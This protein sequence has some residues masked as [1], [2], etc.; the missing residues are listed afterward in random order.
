MGCSGAAQTLPGQELGG[1]A[2]HPFCSCPRARGCKNSASLGF[3][4]PSSPPG[5]SAGAVLLAAFLG[6]ALP[7]PSAPSTASFHDPAPFCGA[8]GWAAPSPLHCS[9]CRASPSSFTKQTPFLLCEQS[10]LFTYPVKGNLSPHDI[11]E[12]SSFSFLVFSGLFLQISLY[13]YISCC[14]LCSLLFHLCLQV[15]SAGASHKSPLQISDYQWRDST[16]LSDLCSVTGQ[17]PE[18]CSAHNNP[19]LDLHL[20]ISIQKFGLCSNLLYELSKTTAKSL[21]ALSDCSYKSFTSFHG[22]FRSQ[23]LKFCSRGILSFRT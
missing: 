21:C 18:L 11:G 20:L 12:L 2:L 16:E 1:F 13:L 8:F 4:V 14:R 23:Q 22:K 3:M 10:T 5:C 9:P 6:R 19:A 17:G 15:G 7:W